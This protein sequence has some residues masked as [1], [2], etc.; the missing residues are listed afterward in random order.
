VVS[1]DVG[2]PLADLRLNIDAPDLERAIAK[3]L[4]SL[5]PA[6][7]EVRDLEGHW[8]SL[9]ILPYRT[10]DNKIDGVVLAL[11]DIDLI[12]AASEQLKQSSDFFQAVMN[13]VMQPLLVLDAELRVVT[14]NES[15]L[16]AFKVPREETTNRQVFSLGSGQWNIPQFRTLL[17]EILPKSQGVVNFSVEHDFENIGPRTMVL[18]AQRLPSTPNV[19]P[20]ILL[21]IEDIT[22]RKQAESKVLARLAAIVE[23]SDDAIIGT[24]LNGT[25]ET[26]NRGAERLFGYTQEEA[27]GKSV[28]FLIP[29]DRVNEG[30]ALL[31]R[32]RHG[33][34]V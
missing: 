3:V 16:T 6:E 12:R 8:H 14:A 11:Q 32:I 33:E 22:E 21:A 9:N 5:R 23:F 29:P 7:H 10:Q 13:T 17:E 31:E 19:K 4:D 30:S 25:I 24:D 34:H 2:R 26:W 1:S 18:N 15:F 28:T 27:I 20:M